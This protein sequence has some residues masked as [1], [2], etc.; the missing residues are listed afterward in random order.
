MDEWEPVSNFY[1]LDLKRAD[2]QLVENTAYK[3]IFNSFTTYGSRL[4]IVQPQRGSQAVT[5]LF[6]YFG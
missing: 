1:R 2:G 4:L 6:A 3:R 5:K